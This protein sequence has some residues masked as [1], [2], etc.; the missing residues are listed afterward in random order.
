MDLLCRA[1]VR[2]GD[3]HGDADVGVSSGGRLGVCPVHWLDNAG[4][5]QSVGLSARYGKLW[6]DTSFPTTVLY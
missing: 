3:C 6:P 5:P 4:T 1:G 2:C